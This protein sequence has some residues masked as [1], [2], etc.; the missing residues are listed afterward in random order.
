MSKKNKL[1]DAVRKNP[2]DV[3][4]DDLC[5][6]CEKAFGKPSKSGGSHNVYKTPWSGD[7]RVNIQNKNGMAKPY[8]VK[9][10]LDAIDKLK[11]MKNGNGSKD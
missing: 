4:F 3:R 2:S 6:I 8:Q 5:K 10:V 11:E 9:Q 1:L 7:P